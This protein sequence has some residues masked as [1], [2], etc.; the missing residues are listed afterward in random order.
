MCIRDSKFSYFPVAVDQLDPS[1]L[2]STVEQ[3]IA[4]ALIHS[5]KRLIV[6][7]EKVADSV[8]IYQALKDKL[9]DQNLL[10]Y[11][12]RLTAKRRTDVYKRL[13][14]LEAT[15]SDYILVSTSAIEVGCDLNARVLITQLCDPEKL[16]QRAGRCNRKQEMPDAEVIVV[17]DKIP[18][19]LTAM[20]NE[21]QAA[22]RAILAE[23]SGYTLNTLAIIACITKQPN[24][25]YR[26][27]MMFEMLYEYVYEARI[28]NKGLHDRGL[29]VTRSWEPTLTL[30][31]GED[32]KGRLLHPIEV[33]MRRCVAG[34]DEPLTFGCWL[35]KDSFDWHDR[36]RQKEPL[37][38]WE[39]AYAIDLIVEM[40]DYPF[41]EETGYIEM[42]KIFNYSY[43]SS[44][45]RVLVREEEGHKSQI[46]YLDP[47][48]AQIEPL[49]AEVAD[50]LE[51]TT[52][53]GE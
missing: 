43:R 3:M 22:Y 39:C 44:Y 24:P 46:W 11:H 49:M 8:A 31:L 52:D 18:E 28:E 40:E 38:R 2:S 34:K 5:R 19:W 14:E 41:D 32:S 35:T 42:P 45:R 36:K 23:Q 33:P 53:D 29:V 20:S 4:M 51:N 27:E 17:G 1:V 10:L 37:G 47:T 15:N 21:A 26:V 9:P 7:A 6:T 16:I 25:D 30:C 50:D 12:G 48:T 13:L